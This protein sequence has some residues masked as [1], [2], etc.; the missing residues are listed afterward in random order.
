MPDSTPVSTPVCRADMPILYRVVR[1][2][3]IADIRSGVFPPGGMLPNETDLARRFAVSVGTVRRAVTELVADNVLVRQQG[4]GTFVGRLDRERDMFQFLKI[5]ARNG[6]RGG[7]REFPDV[8]L[9]AFARSRAAPHEAQALALQ[10]GENVYR[11][12]NVL[13]LQGRAV[14][15]DRIVIAM[16]LLPG[17]DRRMFE[18]RSGTIY[19]LYQSA[20]G[21][22][23]VGADERLRVD[24]AA[25]DSAALLG[26]APG[27][28]VLRIERLAL[29]FDRQPVELRVSI[30]DTREFD[31][32]SNLQPAN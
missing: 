18:S 19:G 8:R 27:A 13:S 15:H 24:A 14:I 30:V 2:Q 22:T 17:L 16:A 12:E 11:I 3:L 32:V 10:A 25:P 23:I 1:R 28:P 21:L 6:A 4:R 5:A 31:Y 20:F 7:A 29:T 26:L 9:H